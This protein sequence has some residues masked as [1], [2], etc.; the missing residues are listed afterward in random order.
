M[1]TTTPN[2]Q[3]GWRARVLQR[4]VMDRMLAGVAVGVADYLEVDVTLVRIALVALTF[5]GG[6]GIPLYVAGWLL[7]PE[8]GTDRSIAADFFGRP[9]RPTTT[10]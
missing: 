10:S 6:A 4:P 7:I 5:V 1:D 3:D 8:E 9:P 2:P